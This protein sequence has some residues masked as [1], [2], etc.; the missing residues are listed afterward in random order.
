MSFP[1]TL[2]PDPGEPDAE[3]KTYVVCFDCGRKLPYSWTE[4]KVLKKRSKNA[5]VPSE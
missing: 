3:P 1:I 5:A 4:M 2:P